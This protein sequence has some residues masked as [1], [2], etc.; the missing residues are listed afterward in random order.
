MESCITPLFD[1][2]TTALNP[3][4]VLSSACIFS[5]LLKVA[6]FATFKSKLKY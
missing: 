5:G 1:L 6:N 3:S 4:V 2:A